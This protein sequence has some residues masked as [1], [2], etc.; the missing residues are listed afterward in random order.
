VKV[1]GVKVKERDVLQLAQ[2]LR[3]TGSRSLASTLE[4]ALV[5]G[6]A[7]VELDREDG[8]SVLRALEAPP[9]GL[10]KLRVALVRRRESHRGNGNGAAGI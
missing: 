2:L 10:E 6:D 9:P 4:G 3:R 8:D 5:V 7:S 1:A